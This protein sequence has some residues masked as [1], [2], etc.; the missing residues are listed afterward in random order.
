MSKEKLIGKFKKTGKKTPC[1]FGKTTNQAYLIACDFKKKTQPRKRFCPGS[2][3]AWRFT[4]STMA[5][6]TWKVSRLPGLTGGLAKNWEKNKEMKRFF[7]FLNKSGKQQTK[8]KQGITAVL[9]SLSW[10]VTKLER[11]GCSS[12]LAIV[13]FLYIYI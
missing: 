8:Q 11:F 3:W 2:D 10:K 6:G 13:M 12:V 5:T 7:F 1:G 4:R 9:G